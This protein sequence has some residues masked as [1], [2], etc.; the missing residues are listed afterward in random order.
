MGNT[1]NTI[2]S[3]APASFIFSYE[4][5]DPK[6]IGNVDLGFSIDKKKSL[7]SVVYNS[8]TKTVLP[9]LE[10][11]GSIRFNIKKLSLAPGIYGIGVRILANGLEADWPKGAIS[12]F[13][14]L[15]SDEY[16]N[17]GY[18]TYPDSV[19]LIDGVWS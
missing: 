11:S 9:K 8:Y 10:S 7:V 12:S 5:P 16:A 19:V 15:P 4:C 17:K 2:K 18:Q 6:E 14:I 13:E 1:V 3:N